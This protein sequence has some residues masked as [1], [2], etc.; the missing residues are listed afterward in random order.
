M[1]GKQ[2]YIETLEDEQIA[3]NIQAAVD[4][5]QRDKQTEKQTDRY[6]SIHHSYIFCCVRLWPSLCENISTI[7][8]I[9]KMC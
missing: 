8:Q 1:T 3:M 5:R 9:L 6:I 2:I 7:K 4:D